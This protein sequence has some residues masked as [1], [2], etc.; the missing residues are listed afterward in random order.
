MEMFFLKLVITNRVSEN[1]LLS[2]YFLKKLIIE[3][4][5]FLYWSL[6]YDFDHLCQS[7]HQTNSCAMKSIK[8]KATE[9]AE[10]RDLDQTKSNKMNLAL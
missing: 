2:F 3:I 7:K 5:S 8:E 1:T 6:I 9:V 10:N 4:Y